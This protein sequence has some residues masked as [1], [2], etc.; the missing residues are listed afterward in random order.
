MPRADDVDGCGAANVV[1]AGVGQFGQ[2]VNAREP[3]SE[4]F[5]R[6][7]HAGDEFGRRPIHR[8]FPISLCCG[9]F[10]AGVV[11]ASMGL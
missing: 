5:M 6:L 10:V 4:F 7:K 1:G 11:T 9:A 2:T 8:C 3:A